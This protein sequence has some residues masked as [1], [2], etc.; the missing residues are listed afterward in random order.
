[1]SDGTA[2][3][4]PPPTNLG[5]GSA[6]PIHSERQLPRRQVRA[7]LQINLICTPRTVG[8]RRRDAG[9]NEAVLRACQHR[10]PATF[11]D[12]LANDR[13]RGR[14]E[15]LAGDLAD[16]RPAGALEARHPGCLARTP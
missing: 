14:S 11:R 16:D 12:L 3:G 8:A 1:V 2:M 13:H 6:E 10:G 5:T 7:G 15:R 4:Y 9:Q